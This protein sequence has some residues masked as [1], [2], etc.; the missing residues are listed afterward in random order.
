MNSNKSKI[1]AVVFAVCLLG[2]AFFVPASSVEIEEKRFD[3]DEYAE[4]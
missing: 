3:Y 2:T 4:E 1:G